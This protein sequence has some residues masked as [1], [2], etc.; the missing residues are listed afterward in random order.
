MPSSPSSGPFPLHVAFCH[1]RR[2]DGSPWFPGAVASG[3]GLRAG[4]LVQVEVEPSES[5]CILVPASEQ[6][7]G[8]V[9]KVGPG[10]RHLQVH[11][12]IDTWA[13]EMDSEFPRWPRKGFYI[14][15]LQVF[16]LVFLRP[17]QWHMEFPRLGV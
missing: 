2:V 3:I 17:H 10:A 9:L 6:L 16:L 4:A 15:L 5:A 7:L 14:V 13:D 12:A 1:I 11:L 8:R